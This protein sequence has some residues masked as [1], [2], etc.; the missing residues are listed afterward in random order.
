MMTNMKEIVRS[1]IENAIIKKKE[2]PFLIVF[3]G[4]PDEYLPV[5]FGTRLVDSSLFFPLDK[6]DVEHV[7]TKTFSEMVSKNNKSTQFFWITFEE[8]C[9]LENILTIAFEI[10][11]I[12]NN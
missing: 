9:V 1:R 11:I 6:I 7:R 8:Y 12:E 4:I 2:K 10:R 3:K 5:D